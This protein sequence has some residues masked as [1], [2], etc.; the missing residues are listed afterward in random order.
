[1]TLS[2]SDYVLAWLYFPM[3]KLS[4]YSESDIGTDDDTNTNMESVVKKLN[5][6]C[7]SKALSSESE[8]EDNLSAS[9]SR[10]EVVS[11]RASR[12]DSESNVAE[13]GDNEMAHRDKSQIH[14]RGMG[15]L[16][17]K[18]AID[19]D[20]DDDDDDEDDSNDG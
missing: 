6:V 17:R 2:L 3:H 12:K 8:S 14:Y 18:K 1:M 9:P 7:Q 13:S 16:L 10:P 11:Q 15:N 20:D 5:A 4:S 19:T